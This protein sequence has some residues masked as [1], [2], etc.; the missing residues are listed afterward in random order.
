LTTRGWDKNK[1]G[2]YMMK[3]MTVVITI[4]ILLGFSACDTFAEYSQYPP[5]Q[6]TE[7]PMVTPAANPAPTPVGQA[8]FL[9]LLNKTAMLSK[10]IR[11]L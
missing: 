5:Q 3:I 10:W 4:L 7:S 11:P 8:R 1:K 2:V 9:P 6:E